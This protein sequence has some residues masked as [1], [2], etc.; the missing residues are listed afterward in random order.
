MEIS[1]EKVEELLQQK[2]AEV[3]SNILA[4]TDL[5]K[6]IEKGFV[7]LKIIPL[8]KAIENNGGTYIFRQTDF[9]NK[10]A[11]GSI[12]A[13]FSKL[14]PIEYQ[15]IDFIKENIDQ[16]Y[17]TKTLW[18]EKKQL[19][20]QVNIE[21]L[22]DINE[23]TVQKNECLNRPVRA[24]YH[25][26]YRGY[27]N[28][29]NPNYINVLKNEGGRES[30]DNLAN[31]SNELNGVLTQN[32]PEIKKRLGYQSLVVVVAPRSKASQS[33]GYQWFRNGIKTWINSQPDHGI[34]DGTGYIV[35]VKDTKCTHLNAD[36]DIA[37]LPYKGITSD[38]CQLLEDL[39]D[40][41]VLFI[42][43]IYTPYVN[44]DEDA[45]Q[46]LLDNNTASV[47]LYTIGRTIK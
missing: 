19:F 25:V 12:S 33:S 9:G 5:N 16:V 47:T 23:F 31:A 27:G 15:N 45:L 2:S 30:E 21:S 46:F 26:N 40:K 10:I 17:I 14:F 28:S 1:Q 4:T 24:F 11:F 3:A 35:R 34:I 18:I 37:P 32:I 6:Q 20:Y 13:N 38:T 42:D 41:H 22:P 29:G 43:D 39:S 44:I 7:V 8:A 36:D